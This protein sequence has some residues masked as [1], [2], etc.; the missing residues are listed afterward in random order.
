[1][2]VVGIA[3]ALGLAGC[4]G[5]DATTLSE[6]AERGKATYTSVC[7]A[8]HSPN[9]GLDGSLGPAV[10]G[11]SRELLELRVVRGEYPPGYAPKRDSKA[12][13]PLPHLA[14]HI[15]DLHAYL[16]ECCRDGER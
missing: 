2:R 5:G 6:A 4:S 7:I 9:P 12:M 11:S 1:M 15:D 8:C 10:A 3:F 16:S 14:G 13:P